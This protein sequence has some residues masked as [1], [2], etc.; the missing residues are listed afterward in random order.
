MNR[1]LID[2]AC[3]GCKYVTT[4]LFRGPWDGKSAACPRCGDRAMRVWDKK[5]LELCEAFNKRLAQRRA[6]REAIKAAKLDTDK[7]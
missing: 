7:V 3:N 4:A 1:Y 5:R 2:V 6:N